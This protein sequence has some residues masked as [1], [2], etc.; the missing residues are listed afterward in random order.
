MPASFNSYKVT[1]A[2]GTGLKLR[3]VG[4]RLNFESDTGREYNVTISKLKNARV[5]KNFSTGGKNFDIDVLPFL[6]EDTIYNVVISYEAYGMTVNNGDNLIFRNGN[7]VYFWRSE[8][9]EYNLETTRE[10]WTD[11]QALKECLEPQNDIESDDPVII[12][13]SNRIVEGAKDDWEKV[14]RIYKFISSDMAYDKVQV[15]ASAAGYQDSAIEVIRSGKAI[16]EGFCNAF[17]ALC[18]AQG[19]PAVVE[20]GIGFSDY[21][22]L[23]TRKPGA[24][25]YADHAWAAVYLGGQWRFVDPTYDMARF[26]Q[27]ENDVAAY[28]D[29]TKY[30]LLPIESFSNDH[31]IMDADTRHGVPIAGYCT[32]N[33]NSARFEITRDG[34][35]H[36]SGSG[37][38]TLP[39]GITGFHTVVFEKE[40]HITEIGADC[41]RDCDLI[42]TVILPESVRQI[43]NSAFNTCEDLHYVY[44]PENVDFIGEK[45]F[46]GCDELSY[47][48]IPD[49][50]SSIGRYA[51][52]YCPRLYISIPKKLSDFAKEY[53]MKP[54]KT[55]VR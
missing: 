36:I 29:S 17:V 14:F 28:N 34:V 27:D 25:D 22:E 8:N 53:D 33:H 26:F 54:M 40:S 1:L 32:G 2:D 18:R 3:T 6:E 31:R 41:F 39:A 44:I 16:C 50:C 55:E 38:L 4:S 43:K 12:G 37:A 7:A 52:E 45:A 5:V 19:I 35:C 47:I 49:S 46:I 24:G 20:F 15:K 30:Y 13:Y 9:Y 51:F 11:E 21:N 48:K 23:T 10:L 42:T